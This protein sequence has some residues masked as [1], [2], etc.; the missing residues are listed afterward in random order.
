M[1]PPRPH[2]L[3]LL[4]VASGVASRAARRELKRRWLPTVGERQAAASEGRLA[5]RRQ[6]IAPHI[7]P[8]LPRGLSVVGGAYFT[9]TSDNL[10]HHF[11]VGFFGVLL[12]PVEAAQG[13]HAHS[14]LCMIMSHDAGG[15]HDI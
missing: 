14:A 12:R 5:D 10:T 1:V 8:Q 15:V 7:T 11:Y 3:H 9:Y 13:T 6:H 4:R 2:F